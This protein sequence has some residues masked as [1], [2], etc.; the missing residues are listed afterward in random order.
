M[1]PRKYGASC[2]I[3]NSKCWILLAKFKINKSSLPSKIIIGKTIIGN[4]T[5]III[6]ILDKTNIADEFNNLFVNVD[7]KLAKKT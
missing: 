5:K 2:W 1:V 4:I 7:L 3:Q 6:G